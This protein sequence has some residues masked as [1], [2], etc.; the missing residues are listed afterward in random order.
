MQSPGS[1]AGAFVGD[2]RYDDSR[3]RR[4]FSGQ[5]HRSHCFSTIQ[6]ARPQRFCLTAWRPWPR[7]QGST[8]MLL[9]TL[10]IL[11]IALSVAVAASLIRLSPV[12]AAD[13]A[14]LIE[15][16]EASWPDW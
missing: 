10:S 12:N 3:W 5:L 1:D 9:R 4:A 2:R 14:R 8:A 13:A 6:P 11:M 15:E 16:L 7:D